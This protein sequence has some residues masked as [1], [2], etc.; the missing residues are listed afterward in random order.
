MMSLV[1]VSSI[2][3]TLTK[4]RSCIVCTNQINSY[5][6]CNVPK[7]RSFFDFIRLK[8]KEKK[9]LCFFIVLPVITVSFWKVPMVVYHS[10]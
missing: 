4:Y 9:M 7:K 1:K 10:I 3:I 2:Y 8:G 5:G 6:N